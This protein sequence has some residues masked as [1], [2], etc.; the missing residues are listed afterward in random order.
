M[1]RLTLNREN[2][3][4]ARTIDTVVETLDEDYSLTVAAVARRL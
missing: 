2:C 1:A 3:G 4:M